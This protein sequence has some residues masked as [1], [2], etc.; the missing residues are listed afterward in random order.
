M[1]V[2][3]T[4]FILIAASGL[5]LG[6]DKPAA[7]PTPLRAVPGD[8]QDLVLFLDTRPYLIRL[9]LQVHGKSFQKSWDETIAHLFRYL[10]ADGDGALS[11]KEAALAPSTTQWV[12]LMGGIPVEPD[13]APE[14]AALAGGEKEKKGTLDNFLRYYRGA[15]G[16]ALQVEWG[17]R[18]PAQDRLTDALFKRLD[19]NKDGALSREE[20][21]AAQATLHLL[22]ADGDEI[23]RAFELDPAGA[24]PVFTFR[25]STDQQPVPAN[26]PFAVLQPDTPADRLAGQILKLY[27]RDKNRKLSRTELPLEKSAFEGLDANRDGELDAVELAGWRKLPPELEMIVPLENNS[28]KDI[29]VMPAMD[30]KPNRLAALHPPAR[31]GA[32]RIPVDEKQLEL[33]RRSNGPTL[34]QNMLKQFDRMAGKNGVLAEKVIYQPPFTFVALLRLADRNGDSQLSRKELAD[35]LELQEKFFFRSSYLTVVDRGPSLFEFLDADHD[36]RL[37][38]REMRSAWTRLAPWDRDGK[39]RLTR[40][41]I[42]RQFQFVLSHGKPRSNLAPAGPG[43]ADMPLFRDRSRGPLWF[44]KMDR[45]ADGDVSQTEFLGTMEQFRRLDADGDGLIDAN[46]ADRADQGLRKR[47]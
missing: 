47:R 18:P 10:D 20:L 44:R 29:L 40:Q 3:F 33:A 32:L 27:D 22:D 46:E 43:Y 13:S 14:F 11:P 25:S 23:I 41:Q 28:R 9:H 21:S 4:F 5:A 16:G 45:N 24:Y 19:K 12:Q 31:D 6:A 2:G 15:G 1:R 34:R 37:S 26:F 42:P 35:F 8:A 17:W 39:G 38:P 30:G 7:A 36:G